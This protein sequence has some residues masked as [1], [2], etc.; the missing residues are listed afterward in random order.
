VK[1]V[2]QERLDGGLFIIG[3]FVEAPAW[4]LESRAVRRDHRKGPSRQMPVL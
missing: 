4:E 3:E 2:R 1:L